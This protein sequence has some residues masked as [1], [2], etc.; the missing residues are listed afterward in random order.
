M[1]E[2]QPKVKA[3]Q[4][5]QEH[6]RFALKKAARMVH[7]STIEYNIVPSMREDLDFFEEFLAPNS[8]VEW[9]APIACLIK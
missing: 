7:H 6:N 3:E 5:S 2:L 4:G 1:Q 8:G 9:D